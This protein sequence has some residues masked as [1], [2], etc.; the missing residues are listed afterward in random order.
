M[1]TA[2]LKDFTKGWFVGNFT[3]SLIQTEDVEIAVKTYQAEDHEASHYHKI[4]TEITV[5][6]SGE[7]T[8]NQVKYQAGDIVVTEPGEWSEFHCLAD[9]TLVVVK[10]PGASNDKYIS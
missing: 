6:I 9:A 7:I 1:K 3:P 2:Q 5:V 4:G 8:M 10:Y